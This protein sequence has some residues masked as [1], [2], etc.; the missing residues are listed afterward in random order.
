MG[1]KIKTFNEK[2][3]KNEFKKILN[4][5][6]N[7]KK[8][9]I[10]L[11]FDN[12]T[13]I[14][15]TPDHLIFTNN[16]SW[17]KA[18]DL[19][20]NDD[21]FCYKKRQPKK[22]KYPYIKLNEYV[23][24]KTNIILYD[25]ENKKLNNKK[26]FECI[27]NCNKK[28]ITRICDQ[29]TKD[30]EFKWI[31]RSCSTKKGWEKDECRKNHSNSNIESWTPERR[32]I[33]Q[34]FFIKRWKNPVFRKKI[35]E[36]LHSEEVQRKSIY[37]SLLARCHI[38]IDAFNESFKSTYEY[39][40]AKCMNENNIEWQYEPKRFKIFYAK[41]KKYKHYYP[42]FY[43]PK[44]DLWIETKGHWYKGTKNKFKKFLKQYPEIKIKVFYE[45]QI[46][47]IECGDLSEIVK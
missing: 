29:K 38:K 17:V 14:I 42:D 47:K 7:G 34:K 5:F 44:Y 9:C 41:N 25:L 13:E 31:C 20:E 15:C 3:K 22:T 23:L 11:K 43:L 36:L 30:I 40:F 37:L 12:G 1:L 35:V 16:R 6:N 33:S 4:V 24:D 45:K 46:K 21:V 39:R 10:K 18:D 19:N 26:R 32:E 28:F 27:C 8:E 2:T